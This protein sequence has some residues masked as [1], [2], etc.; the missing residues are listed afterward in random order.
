MA[1]N[2]VCPPDVVTNRAGK[3]PW[4]IDRVGIRGQLQVSFVALAAKWISYCST[5]TERADHATLSGGESR[6]T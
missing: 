2:V 4:E 1:E 3:G 6:R 5:G